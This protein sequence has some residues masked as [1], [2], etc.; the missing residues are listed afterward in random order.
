M[1]LAEAVKH[2][3]IAVMKHRGYSQRR[4]ARELGWKQQY[5]WRRISLNSRADQE[6]TPSEIE[7]IATVFGLPV[8]ELLPARAARSS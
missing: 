6:L 2:S 8:E 7:Q 1:A 5:L 4:L 3:I